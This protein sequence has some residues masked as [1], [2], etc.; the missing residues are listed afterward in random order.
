LGFPEPEIAKHSLAIERIFCR[1]RDFRRIAARY[2]KL[3]QNFLAA[4]CTG[5]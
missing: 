2:D 1:L 3:A 4:V 5:F